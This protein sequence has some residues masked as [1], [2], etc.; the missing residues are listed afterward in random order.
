MDNTIKKISGFCNKIGITPQRDAKSAED[1]MINFQFKFF[2]NLSKYPFPLRDAKKFFEKGDFSQLNGTL[3]ELLDL[4]DNHV[5][6][7]E[8]IEKI[9]DIFSKNENKNMVLPSSSFSQG[10]LDL[11]IEN[12]VNLLKKSSHKKQ[13][14]QTENLT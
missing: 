14:T 11:F 7:T 4:I 3:D 10:S 13:L 6:M 8:S 9:R 1:I 5:K 12:I 2:L